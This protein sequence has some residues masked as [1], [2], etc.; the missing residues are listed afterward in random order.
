VQV[1]H[2]GE[3]VFPGQFEE[4]QMIREFSQIGVKLRHPST[5]PTTRHAPVTAKVIQVCRSRG[6][7]GWFLFYVFISLVNY[8]K[9]RLA[10][11][12]QIVYQLI[13]FFGR[14]PVVW[15]VSPVPLVLI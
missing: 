13:K 15:Y 7:R 4:K 9:F 5:N 6:Q 2:I 8:K 11:Y 14:L 3:V 12:H 1:F 10:R